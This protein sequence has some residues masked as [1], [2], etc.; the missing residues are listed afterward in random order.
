MSAAL[1]GLPVAG[2]PQSSQQAEVELREGVQGIAQAA[3]RRAV[4]AELFADGADHRADARGLGS[5]N[6]EQALEASFFRQKLDGAAD[7][8]FRRELASSSRARRKSTSAA[9][10]SERLAHASGLRV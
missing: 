6:P 3:Q 1:T 8:F 9:S 4:L 2:V 5:R 7:G 10:L